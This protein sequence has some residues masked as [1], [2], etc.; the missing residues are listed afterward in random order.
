MLALVVSTLSLTFLSAV[1]AS[2]PR[3]AQV[4]VCC[5]S[6]QL[7]GF[8]ADLWQWCDIESD[9]DEMK[10]AVECLDNMPQDWCALDSFSHDEARSN[11]LLHRQWPHEAVLSI[12]YK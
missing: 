1:K 12:P 6:W 8:N 4:P 10:M 2:S 7:Y 9:D 11:K 3:H 5:T